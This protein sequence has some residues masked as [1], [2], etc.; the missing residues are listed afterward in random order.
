MT[1]KIEPKHNPRVMILSYGL[2]FLT[3]V[4]SVFVFLGG[5][6]AV[7]RTYT[8]FL[9]METFRFQAGQG[10][11]SLLNILISL[12]LALLVIAIIIGGFEFQHRHMGKPEA[13]W[14]LART[15]AVETA[16]L[17]LASFI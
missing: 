3:T 1:E 10:G 17:M 11:I 8:R 9:P 12:P 4:M 7:I 6:E 13:W 16:V 2:W 15:L 5:R 14:M